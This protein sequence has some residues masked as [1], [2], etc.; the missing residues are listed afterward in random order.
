MI[1]CKPKVCKPFLGGRISLGGFL[2]IPCHSSTLLLFGLTS[3]EMYPRHGPGATVSRFFAVKSGEKRPEPLGCSPL[4]AHIFSTPPKRQRTLSPQPWRLFQPW[5]IR[6]AW[7]HL[8]SGIIRHGFNFT[9]NRSSLHL[10]GSMQPCWPVQPWC[11][12]LPRAPHGWT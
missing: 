12:P 9:V 1:V 4:P 11:C 2:M 7:N 10:P 8:K 3:V 5:A 6:I